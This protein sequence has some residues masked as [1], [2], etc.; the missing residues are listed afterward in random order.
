[1]RYAG[2]AFLDRQ[3]DLKIYEYRDSYI[4]TTFKI[5]TRVLAET[6]NQIH[7]YNLIS[8]EVE[9]LFSKLSDKNKKIY[10]LI[11]NPLNRFLS[12]ATQLTFEG[13]T[14]YTA[15]YSLAKWGSESYFFTKFWPEFVNGG[16]S[17]PKQLYSA[18]FDTMEFKDINESHDIWKTWLDIIHF[19]M[20]MG[21]S[22]LSRY[23][24]YVYQN[25]YKVIKDNYNV[26]IVDDY[27]MKDNEFFKKITNTNLPNE[28]YNNKKW[29]SFLK[30]TLIYDVDSELPRVSLNPFM[31]SDRATE[32]EDYISDEYWYYNKFKNLK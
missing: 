27:E 32:V 23:H 2:L 5:G 18:Y 12:A 26:S 25:C 19:N 29:V 4:L 17:N 22:H 30:K 21:D 3:C 13:A 10:I 20:K 1:M 11:K 15:A 8:D 14:K 7:D 31:L 6:T 9:L 28:T 16:L 24:M